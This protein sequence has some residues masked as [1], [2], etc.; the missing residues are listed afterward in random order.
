MNHRFLLRI[1]TTYATHIVHIDTSPIQPQKQNITIR[2]IDK[3][4]D[5]NA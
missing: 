2:P 3:T 4:N 5:Q 1:V